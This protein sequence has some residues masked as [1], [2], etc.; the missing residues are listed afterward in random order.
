MNE[1]EFLKKLELIDAELAGKQV[2][3]T[4]RLFFCTLISGDPQ[5][6]PVF[7]SNLHKHINEWYEK[8][9]GEECYIHGYVGKVPIIIRKKIYL[10]RIPSA[11]GTIEVSALSLI[12]RLSEDM[13]KSLSEGEVNAIGKAFEAAFDLI[14]K[15]KGLEA[16]LKHENPSS[17]SRDTHAMLYHAIED[18]DTAINHLSSPFAI[19]TNMA[20]FYAQQYAEKMLKSFLMWKG[21]VT[22]DESLKNLGRDLIII[23]NKC[24]EISSQFISIGND[25]VLL[26][27]VPLDIRYT[28]FG[29]APEVAVETIWSALRVGGFCACELSGL[30]ESFQ[31][32]GSNM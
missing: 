30:A 5:H 27:N 9:Y 18:C 28:I 7:G 22:D 2:L 14:C 32:S 21:V 12:E 8:R 29:A 6:P 13:R 16:K 11:F 3:V 25:I 26:N 19:N 31:I 17:F 24:R 23:F 1:I 20:C 15:T 10:L 4:A